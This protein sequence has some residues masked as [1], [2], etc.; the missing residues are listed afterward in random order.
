MSWTEIWDGSTYITQWLSACAW[1]T[2][3]GGTRTSTRISVTAGNEYRFI[4]GNRCRLRWED[5]SNDCISS[6]DAGNDIS[7]VTRTAPANAT[8]VYYYYT[9]N[10]HTDASVEE[11]IELLEY[12]PSG[13]YTLDPIDATTLPTN[14]RIKWSDDTPED[15]S[16]TAEYAVIDDDETPPESWTAIENSDTI[17]NPQTEGDFLWLRFTLE[18]EDD[19]V[20]PTLLAVWLEEAEAPPDTII[21]NF[22]MYNR[23]NDVEGD[24]TV[25]YNQNLGTLAG[26]RAVESFSIPFTPTDLQRTPDSHEQ[27]SA[28]ITDYEITVSLVTY[29][30]AYSTDHL[31]TG[32]TNYEITVT[33]VGEN[34]L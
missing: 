15:T 27:L 10:S 14:P 2:Q 32:I 30:N 4:G 9:N 8:G 21:L 20:T 16:I 1:Q 17:T 11:W 13:T 12:K 7:P 5:S 29:R 6:E 19:T 26:A 25:A 28:G 3:S 24:L 18:T 33:K 31:S 34:P 22:D 23:F